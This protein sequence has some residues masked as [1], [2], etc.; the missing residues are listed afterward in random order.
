MV[1][2]YHSTRGPRTDI[3][4]IFDDQYSLALNYQIVLSKRTARKKQFSA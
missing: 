3:D 1:D 4:G 2:H